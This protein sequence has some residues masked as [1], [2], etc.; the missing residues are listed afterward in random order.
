MIE[1]L[2]YSFMQNA[3]I[4]LAFASLIC[5]IA[6]SLVVVNRTVYITGGVAHASYGGIGLALWAGFAPMLGA[7]AVAVIMGII[8]GIV[9]EKY[10]SKTDA[11]VSALWAAGMAA[12][13]LLS[14]ITP[15]FAS[16][17]LSYLFGD[18]LLISGVDILVTVIFTFVIIILTVKYYRVIL[19]SSADQQFAASAGVNVRMVNILMLVL[20]CVAVVILM[21]VA[22]LVLVMALLAIPASIAESYSR[23][24]S[25]MMF[26]SGVIAL[27]SMFTGLIASVWLDL[28]PGAAI[29][30]ILSMLYLINIIIKR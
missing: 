16:D 8:L 4:T 24:L 10:S 13:V 3:V 21:R 12:G 5:A 6:G 1:L 14:D 9:R 19:A 11:L 7:V 20:L 28:T 15:G 23:K 17:Y 27:L 29:V 18:I 25:H 30:A 26:I 22:G 2:N